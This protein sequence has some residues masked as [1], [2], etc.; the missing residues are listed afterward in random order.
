MK[1][2]TFLYFLM[3][4]AGNLNAQEIAGNWAGYLS[5]QGVRLKLVFHIQ[6]NEGKFTASFD[7]PDQHAMDLK[8]DEVSLTGSDL[9]LNAKTL[10]IQFQG[11]LDKNHDSIRGFWIQ[12]QRKFLLTLGK[13]KLKSRIEPVNPY[14]SDIILKTAKGDI[15]GTLTLPVNA[16]GSPVV[17]IIA[18]SGPT[19]R[20]GNSP[21]A[22]KNS[23]NCYK[24]L[25]EE[26]LKNG[27]A[28]VRYDKRGIAGSAAAATRERDLSIE[29]YISDAKGWI[30]MLSKDKRFTK[31]FVA[32]HSEGS[33]I[34]MIAC[35]RVKVNAYVSISGSGRPA[36]EILKEQ[37][38]SLPQSEKDQIFPILDKLKNGDTVSNL[39]K[40]LQ[41]F[42]R[43]GIQPY[44]ISWFRYN[45]QSE[46]KKLAIPVLILQ[47]DMDIQVSVDDAML[48][49]KG[50]EQA[51]V[52][53]IH[54]MNHVLKDTDTMDKEEQV[55]KIY[56]N[57][58]L[59]VDKMFIDEMVEFI[60]TAK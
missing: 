24:L 60:H 44:L 49:A 42:F 48:L 31:I 26:L 22:L 13:I 14:E 47:G 21:P 16:T 19:D 12:G 28:S 51:R 17:L 36:D 2:I 34:G 30:E 53:V 8:F 27:I 6:K 37:F 39:P 35:E 33:L 7:S 11:T 18:G 15:S 9:S 4:I 56:M 25:A 41:S 52:A 45:P 43:P 3:L 10:G 32:G 20:D 29:N 5:V 23:S 1:K 59:P 54:R 57:P 46:I 58:D 40:S 38:A 50:N 55:N